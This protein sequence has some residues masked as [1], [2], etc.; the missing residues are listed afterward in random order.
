MDRQLQDSINN[1]DKDKA[2]WEGRFAFLE[3]QRDQSKRDL[4]EAS[5][6]FE[7]T[8]TQLQ[9]VQTDNKSKIDSS[10]NNMMQ[11][12]QQQLSQRLKEA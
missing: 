6:K 8:I 12:M 4:E 9:K 10:H 11:Q 5:Q 7:T 3:Q 2:L 1:Y